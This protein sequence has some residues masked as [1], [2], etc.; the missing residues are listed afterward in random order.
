VA[1]SVPPKRVRL[2]ARLRELRALRFR[3]GSELARALE[4]HQTKVSKVERGVQLPT[5]PELER[6]VRETGAGVD[7]LEE[8]MGLLAAAR[9]DYR[10]WGEAWQTSGGIAARQDEIAALDAQATRIW[11]YQPAMVPGLIQT[12]AYAREALAVAGGP[13]VLGAEPDQ[14]EERVAAQMR[15]QQVLYTPGKTIQM[16]MGEAALHTRF[17]ERSTLLG[18]LDRLIALAGLENVEIGV[19]RFD[20]PSPVLPLAGFAVNDAQV[21][22]VETLTGEQRLDDPEE[23]DAYVTAF[24]VALAAAARGADAVAVIREALS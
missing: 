23:V 11:E 13:R 10:S 19:L 18:Q 20:S 22:W 3:S 9:L 6:W 15:R 1:S 14:I 21:V 4:W 8:L 2:G 24:E 5:T 7:A 12:P 17:G 16:V